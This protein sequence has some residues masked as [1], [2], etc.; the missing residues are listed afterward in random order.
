[1]ERL[2]DDNYNN[3]N[4]NAR[5]EAYAILGLNEG[6]DDDSIEKR[7][8]LLLRKHKAS[9]RAGLKPDR[10]MDQITAA[11]DLLKGNILSE[12]EQ[13]EPSPFFKKLGINP[14]KASNF[15]S[16][17]KWYIVGGILAI[18]LSIS[19]IKTMTRPRPDFRLAF[20]GE[21]WVENTVGIEDRIEER[22]DTIEFAYIDTAAGSTDS[23]P[24]MV[25]PQKEAALVAAGDIDVFIVDKAKY[26]GYAE[27]GLFISLDEYCTRQEYKAYANSGLILSTEDDPEE[28]QFGI[29]VTESAVFSE[30]KIIGEQLI[31]GISYKSKQPELA[32]EVL[33]LLAERK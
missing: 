9:I 13:Y 20:L 33:K 16:Y 27:K 2:K 12:E 8:L 31:A 21:M 32:L 6:A 30:F 25:L 17:N 11:Y 4:N 14:R 19:V 23:D 26:E 22:I 1:M 28:H 10:G 24:Y 15:F 5:C 18:L 7:Y 3:E 29:D